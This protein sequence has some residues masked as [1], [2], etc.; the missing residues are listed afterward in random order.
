MLGQNVV[1]VITKPRM[2]LLEL[3]GLGGDALDLVLGVVGTFGLGGYLRLG[4]K[5]SGRE[6]RSDDG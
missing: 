1:L 2:D 6:S 5:N 4:S 3:P